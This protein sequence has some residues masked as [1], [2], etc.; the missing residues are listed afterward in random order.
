MDTIV[1]KDMPRI[2]P[3]APPMSENSLKSNESWFKVF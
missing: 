3:A 2:K 1:E